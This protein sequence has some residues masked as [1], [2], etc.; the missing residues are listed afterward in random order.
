MRVVATIEDPVVIRRILTHLGL[1]IEVPHQAPR[2]PRLHRDTRQARGLNRPFRSIFPCDYST[3][4]PLGEAIVVVV[5]L[6]V[7]VVVVGCPVVV[8]VVVLVVVVVEPALCLSLAN[9]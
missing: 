2:C 5:V 1:S 7:V 9:C 6:L 4:S 8:V 3:K